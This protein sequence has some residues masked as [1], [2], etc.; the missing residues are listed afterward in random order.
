MNCD[1]CLDNIAP[2][3]FTIQI[4]GV[5]NAPA[6]LHC[7]YFN[8]TFEV[9]DQ[10]NCTW[11]FRETIAFPNICNGVG[12][13]GVFMTL[14]FGGT[15]TLIQIFGYSGQFGGATADVRFQ[16][17]VPGRQDCLNFNELNIPPTFKVINS[18]TN[19]NE[20]SATC[21]LTSGPMP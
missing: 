9:E 3:F 14:S 15:D 12:D 4:S 13:S 11:Q 8:N 18:S 7:N 20:Q 10:G 21:L 6:C 1:G 17:T 16:R 19:C 2:K 5:V